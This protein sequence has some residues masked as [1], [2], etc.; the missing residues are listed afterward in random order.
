MRRMTGCELSASLSFCKCATPQCQHRR[1]AHRARPA[2]AYQR[3]TERNCGLERGV[4]RTHV[5]NEVLRKS[6][7]SQYAQVL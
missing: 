3:S 1:V 4:V 7:G 2:G 6:Q 5:E